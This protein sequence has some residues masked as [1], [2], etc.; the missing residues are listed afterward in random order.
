MASFYHENAEIYYEEIGSGEPIIAVHGLIENTLYWK[1]AAGALSEKFR[2]IAMDM[3]GHG[4]TVVKK[5]PYGFDAESIGN[6]IIALADHLQIDRFHLLTHS[7]GGFA[8]VRYAMKDSS[9]FASL[10]L[11]NTGSATSPLPGS[12]EDIKKFN[13]GFARTFEK[14]EWN[15]MIEN[16]KKNPGPFFRGI[17]ESDR[18]EDLMEKARE[19]VSLGNREVIAKF[20]RLF[21]T[22][23]DPGVD[24]LRKI[25]C[26][27]LIIYGEKDDLFIQSSRLMADE[28]P[29]AHLIE[30]KGIGHMTALEAPERLSKD[31]AEFINSI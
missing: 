19:M 12:P 25:F 3:R 9:R 4:R 14:Y 26:P 7:S 18:A 17:M 28:I 29:N 20:V 13:D 27:T 23:P 31:I 2:F 5:E 1:P 16:L 15:Q 22:D 8:A 21:Y 24:G 11:T 30:Y 10:I 6:D